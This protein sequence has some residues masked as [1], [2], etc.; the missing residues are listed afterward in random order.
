MW[1]SSDNHFKYVSNHVLQMDSISANWKKRVH[2]A[3]AGV[4]KENIQKEIINTQL[5]LVIAGTDGNKNTYIQFLFY[6]CALDNQY[7]YRKKY[8]NYIM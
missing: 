1:I 5:C 8:F 3:D 7:Y 4:L 2:H 6:F